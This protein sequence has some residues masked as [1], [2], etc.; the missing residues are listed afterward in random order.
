MK[1]EVN[2]ELYRCT[3][4][5]EGYWN[6]R[7]TRVFYR[8]V[9]YIFDSD[10]FIICRKD[11]PEAEAVENP[12]VFPAVSRIEAQR[13]YIGALNNKKLQN[14]FKNLKDDEYWK[15]F[16]RY[17]DDGARKLQDYEI[18]EERYR[19]KRIVDW[20]EENYIPYFINKG[21]KFIKH[22]MDYNICNVQMPDF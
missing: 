14:D 6:E 11:A 1:L 5:E 3:F 7:M 4:S 15:L 18:F 19:I 16:W 21:D 20:C 13:A 2:E 8:T 17:F 12:I 22:I 10:S 9:T